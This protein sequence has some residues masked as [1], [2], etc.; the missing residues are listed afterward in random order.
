MTDEEQPRAWRMVE[1]GQPKTCDHHPGLRRPDNGDCLACPAPNILVPEDMP[2]DAPD[3]GS[4]RFAGMSDACVTLR[5]PDGTASDGVG[6]TFDEADADAHRRVSDCCGALFAD[7]GIKPY[8]LMLPPPPPPWDG[9]RTSA[10]C[11][12]ASF[13]WVHVR[14]GCRCPR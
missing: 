5:M 8:D 12:V 11:Y 10:G 3:S 1:R 9:P 4:Y 2:D 7:V 6:R 13:G 14:P